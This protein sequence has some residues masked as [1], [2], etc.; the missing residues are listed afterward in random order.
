MKPQFA[1]RHYDHRYEV[2]RRSDGRAVK[3]F[4][5]DSELQRAAALGRA[6]AERAD[7]NAEKR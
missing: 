1:V 3:S 5:Y 7:L 4:P 6:N 2:Y